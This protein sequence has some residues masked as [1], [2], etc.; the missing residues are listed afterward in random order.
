M[1]RI[2]NFTFAT[3]VTVTAIVMSAIA[4]LDRGSTV[5]DKTL[6]VAISVAICIGS[7]LI[8]S[9]SKTKLAWILWL[10]CLVSAVYSHITFF[11]FAKM[12]ANDERSLY[13]IQKSNVE[14]EIEATRSALGR[15]EARPA[16][17]VA[18]ELAVTKGW[19]RRN[20]FHHVFRNSIHVPV[21]S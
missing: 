2:T 3:F 16:A 1:I 11:S 7:H 8:L 12:R 6:L 10:L 18:A 17:K 15:I 9:I 19:N 14:R 5:I 13:S 20:A 4:A 21:R